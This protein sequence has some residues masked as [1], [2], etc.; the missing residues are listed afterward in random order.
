MIKSKSGSNLKGIPFKIDDLSGEGTILYLKLIDD[1]NS[2]GIGI[3]NILHINLEMVE[4]VEFMDTNEEVIIDILSKRVPIKTKVY[5]KSGKFQVRKA[6]KEFEN[7]IYKQCKIEVCV[8]G[9]ELP[10]DG[11]QLGRLLQLTGTIHR[12]VLDVLES[13]DAQESWSSLFKE[14]E[15]VESSKFEVIKKEMTLLIH[16]PFTDVKAE[17]IPD[18]LL[19]SLILKVL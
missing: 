2:N 14:V 16:F 5:D 1:Y 18:E 15:F 13:E 12:V 3:S 7:T 9:F 6:F 10:E 11:Q 4:Y 17:E 8:Q 19:K